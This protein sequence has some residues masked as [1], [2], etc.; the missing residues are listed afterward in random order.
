MTDAP[1]RIW[2]DGDI[3]VGDGHWTRC[4]EHA[5]PCS[6]PALEYIRADL[7]Q[8]ALDADREEGRRAG[9]EEAATLAE[10]FS[11]NCRCVKCGHPRSNH[12]FRHPFQA[13]V[14]SNSICHS[15]RALI[16]KPGDQVAEA[17]RL[18]ADHIDRDMN[19]A[20]R[21]IEAYTKVT[22][23]TPVRHWLSQCLRALAQKEG[24]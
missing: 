16:D 6:E 24:E 1:E 4:F 19:A 21:M 14:S 3:E 20:N 8:Q 10:T 22:M 23:D 12:P 15:I 2:M 13:F 9:L 5:K 17:A 7:H 11:D 18:L